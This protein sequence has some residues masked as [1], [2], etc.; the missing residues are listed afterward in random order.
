MTSLSA[1]DAVVL[2]PGDAGLSLCHAIEQSGG[3]AIHFPTLEIEPLVVDVA[4]KVQ[5]FQPDWLIA[6]S[7]H[8]VCFGAAAV[9][10]GRWK[11][12]AVGAATANEMQHFGID[13]ALYCE[14]NQSTEGLLSLSQ[15]SDLSGQR[16]MIIRGEGGRETLA[17]QLRLRGAEVV[18][19]EVYRRILPKQTKPIPEGLLAADSG[20]IVIAASHQAVLNLLQLLGQKRQQPIST[21]KLLVISQRMARLATELG[22]ERITV[23]DNASNAALLKALS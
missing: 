9:E 2:R 18:Y 12:A 3:K 5:Q 13:D 8:A 23:A 10:Q 7:R 1:V 14:S 11:W 21:M 19:L 16:V 22:F 15:L 6:V 20:V 4:T 17:E